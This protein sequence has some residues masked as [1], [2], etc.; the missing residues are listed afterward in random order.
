MQF[1]TESFSSEDYERSPRLLT[2]KLKFKQSRKN[3]QIN[4]IVNKKANQTAKKFRINGQ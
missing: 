4:K 1:D 3:I 2:N